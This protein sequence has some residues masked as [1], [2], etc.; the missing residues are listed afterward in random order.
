M[1]AGFAFVD[2]FV[3]AWHSHTVGL[4][5]QRQFY[6]MF[7]QPTLKIIF[8]AN[9]DSLTDVK[10]NSLSSVEVSN[11]IHKGIEAQMGCFD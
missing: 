1:A 4:S 6:S 11:Y 5:F 10:D 8:K 9:N 3:F 7:P 2:P